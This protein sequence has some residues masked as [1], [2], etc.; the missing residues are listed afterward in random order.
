MA[1]FKKRQA[2]LS[3]EL[4]WTKGRANL[5]WHGRQPY[6]REVVNQLAEWLGIEPYELLMPPQEA[7]AMRR[8]RD[9]AR[10]IVAEDAPTFEHGD[11]AK[12]E[13][14]RFAERHPPPP[15]RTGT[16]G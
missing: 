9:A 7:L 3:N 8:L 15:R 13:A 4:G 5:V 16:R 1:H 10:T 11:A 6:R 12:D 2:T 14:P